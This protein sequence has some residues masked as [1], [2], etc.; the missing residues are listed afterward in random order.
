MY[1]NN[2]CYPGATARAAYI[3]LTDARACHHV[4]REGGASFF[5]GLQSKNL[6]VQLKR[7]GFMINEHRRSA[8]RRGLK[9]SMGL[10]TPR[11]QI[12]QSLSLIRRLSL[13]TTMISS[14]WELLSLRTVSNYTQISTILI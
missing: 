7:Y 12:S 8:I 13:V 2:I 4:R 10:E 5:S 1:I 6:Y 11:N 14:L 9:K 3:I